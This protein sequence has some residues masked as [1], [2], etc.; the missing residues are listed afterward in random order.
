MPAKG[1]LL[2]DVLRCGIF[3][4]LGD[5]KNDTTKPG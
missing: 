4:A 1:Q 5:P 2:I 3:D